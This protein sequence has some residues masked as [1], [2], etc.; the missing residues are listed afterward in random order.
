MFKFFKE[1][2]GAI[3]E[4]VEEGKAEL[5]EEKMA[6]ELAVAAS[7]AQLEAALA[8]IVQAPDLETRLAA[9]A[10]PYR[11]IYAGHELDRERDAFQPLA[12]YRI[13]LA[14]ADKPEW[15]K[16]V[17][18]DFGVADRD[19]ARSVLDA[20]T[21]IEVDAT[22]PH[23]K[24]DLAL[25]MVRAAHLGCAAVALG[26]LD[27][28]DLFVRQA[29]LPELAR[30]HFD[31]WQDFGLAF[32]AG[33]RRSPQSNPLSRRFLARVVDELQAD[34]LAPWHRLPWHA[35]TAALSEQNAS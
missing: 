27:K 34:A 21:P 26:Y 23:V 22:Q 3:R 29:H 28:A 12:L 11:R 1:M 18:R 10:A 5:A 33:E 2:I 25:A 9:F 24:H 17:I 4:G 13:G 14:D 8:A 6:R 19:S 15:R 31:S 30:Q 16:L 35:Q 7:T 20:I 32:L